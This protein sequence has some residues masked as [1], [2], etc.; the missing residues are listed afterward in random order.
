MQLS[1]LDK[2]IDLRVS[3]NIDVFASGVTPENLWGPSSNDSLASESSEESV[4][5]FSTAMKNNYEV[6]RIIIDDILSK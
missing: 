6:G 4:D 2:L 3:V 5:V 1:L